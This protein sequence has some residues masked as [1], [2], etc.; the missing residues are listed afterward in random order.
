MPMDS[1]DLKVVRGILEAVRSGDEVTHQLLRLLKEQS[2]KNDAGTAKAFNRVADAL[3]AM[4]AEI[5][6]LRE[7]LKPS[8]QKPRALRAQKPARGAGGGAP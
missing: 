7:D 2:V 3:E 6:G 4:T 5:R 1:T 8:M